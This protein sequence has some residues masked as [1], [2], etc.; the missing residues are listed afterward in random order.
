MLP[1]RLSSAC[2][3]YVSFSCETL[4]RLRM[5][6]FVNGVRLWKITLRPTAFFIRSS[7]AALFKVRCRLGAAWASL[8]GHFGIALASFLAALGT[9]FGANLVSRDAKMT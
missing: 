1:G 5:V 2:D 9:R 7:R 6:G 4:P 8:W 3:V